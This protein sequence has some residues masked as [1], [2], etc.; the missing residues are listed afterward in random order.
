M[1]LH[2]CESLAQAEDTSSRLLY[3]SNS[4]RNYTPC[5]L[6]LLSETLKSRISF[7]FKFLWQSRYEVFSFVAIIFDTLIRFRLLV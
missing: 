5:Y 4:N 7:H 3:N 2:N 6:E 1:T